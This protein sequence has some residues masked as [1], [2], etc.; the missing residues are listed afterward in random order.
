MPPPRRRARPDRSPVV[1]A[2]TVVAVVVSLALMWSVV[3]FASENPDKAD[4][5]DPIFQV[6]RAE[7]LAREIDERGPFLF[8]DPLSRGRGRNLYVQHLG[9]DPADGWLAVEAR[10]PD[11]P[12]CVV[13]WDREV[14]AFVDCDGER[15]PGDG[16]G[17]RTYPGTV[18]GGQVSIDLRTSTSS[19]TSTTTST[20]AAPG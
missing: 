16:G 14:E 4:L 6:G 15:Y 9:D 18:A 1:L 17:L 11:R 10:L 3:R 13:A 12:D 8:Q 19:T 2:A 20:A 5:G 7:R